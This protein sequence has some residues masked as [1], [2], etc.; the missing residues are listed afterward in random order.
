MEKNTRKL[1]FGFAL[2]LVLWL[3]TPLL[4]ALWVKILPQNMKLPPHEFG[5]Q[6][7][8][9]SALFSGLAL[10]LAF[11]AILWQSKQLRQIEGDG[12]K[13]QEASQRML[14]MQALIS[15]HQAK[16]NDIMLHNQNRIDFLLRHNQ[17]AY[18]LERNHLQG[19]IRTT[20]ILLDLEKAYDDQNERMKN[21]LNHL[22]AIECKIKKLWVDQGL[23]EE[24][25]ITSHEPFI[26]DN[27]MEYIKQ[28]GLL[29]VENWL[30]SEIKINS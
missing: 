21:G 24:D 18:D 28:N 3:L 17:L 16:M 7:G 19:D 9:V 2:V 6:F 10:L 11:V 8:P 5:E 1:A 13:Q 30:R 25:F 26:A 15:I 4:V 12:V 27:A 29:R 22:S 20:K 23:K 14:A